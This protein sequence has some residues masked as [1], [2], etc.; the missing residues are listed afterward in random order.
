MITIV[1]GLQWGDEGKGKVIDFL[2][3]E[4]DII[5]RFQGGA[6]A[7]HTVYL[8]DQPLIFHLLP[9]GLHRQGKTGVI[10]PGVVLDI[11]QLVQ[12][13][14]EMEKYAGSLEGRLW[15]DPRTAL[16]LPVHQAEDGWE[17]ELKGGVGS[18]RRGIGPTYRDV[19]ARL[20]LRVGDLFHP[21]TLKHKLKVALDFNNQILGARYGKP[22]FLVET[23][24]PQLLEWAEVI[25]PFVEDTHWFL[26]SALKA[27]R[28]ILFEGAQGTLLD[29]FFGTYPYVTSS[30]TL[31]S[32]ALISLGIGP[33]EVD[34]IYGVTKAYTTRVGKG[35]F[36][37]EL[38]GEQGT[39][40][41]ERGHEY[42]ATTGRPRRCGW[43]D[44]VLL[45]YAVSL[46]GVTRLAVTKVDVLA[47]L[48]EVKVAT[49]YRLDGQDRRVPPASSEDLERVQPLYQTFPGWNEFPRPSQKEDLPEPLQ[50]YLTYIEEFVEVPIGFISYGRRTDE[51][52]AISES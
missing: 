7:G 44:L 10:G 36:P 5:V 20:G 22:P 9:T 47:G 30:H 39:I 29:I 41:R 13:I 34:R 15:I 1:V 32:G 21:E 48:P 52:L 4:H 6:N 12:E 37:T 51:I 26:R 14:R 25:R 43:L 31:A 3:Q 35:P 42:G 2:S 38:K 17:E 23:V 27:N 45:K 33:K 18:T 24:Y 19:Y 16:V 49:S 28:A 11:Q 40:L 50:R 46:N 8:D